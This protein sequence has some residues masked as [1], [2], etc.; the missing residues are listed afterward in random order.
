MG[1]ALKAQEQKIHLLELEITSTQNATPMLDL[2]PQDMTIALQVNTRSRTA[3]SKFGERDLEHNLEG[4]SIHISEE[5]HPITKKRKLHTDRITVNTEATTRDLVEQLGSRHD[6]PAF[7][8]RARRQ[9]DHPKSAKRINK[10]RFNRI[11][12]ARHDTVPSTV[13]VSSY[14]CIASPHLQPTLQNNRC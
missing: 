12:R 3:K 5:I 14:P 8:T 4:T 7:N 1:L 10:V 11:K 9:V 13:P 2:R 6:A